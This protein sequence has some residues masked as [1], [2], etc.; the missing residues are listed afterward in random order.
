MATTKDFIVK[1]GLVVSA[2]GSYQSTS[3]TTGAIVTPGGVGIGGN[4][5]VGGAANIKG[6][7][8]VTGNVNLSGTVKINGNVTLLSPIIHDETGVSVDTS[9][10]V[11][12]GFDVGLYR[13]ARYFVSVSNATTHKYQ[14]TDILLVQD[15]TNAYVE[16]TSV[17]SNGDN[18]MSF[19][20]TVTGTSVL[21]MGQGT[22]AN[23]VVKVQTTY[24]T[25]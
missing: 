24:I 11:L 22:D 17:F 7:L 16:Q 13:S 1:N 15:G 20:A 23:N 12:D 6:S 4:L 2:Q 5:N 10:V 14:S 19:S 9:S 25:V 21:L 8:G 3:T 18:I